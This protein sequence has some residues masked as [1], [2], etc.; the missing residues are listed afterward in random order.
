[1]EAQEAIKQAKTR[2]AELKKELEHLKSQKPYDEMTVSCSPPSP[3][4]MMHVLLLLL[5]N[6]SSTCAQI[7]E[8]LADKPELRRQIEVDIKNYH[9]Y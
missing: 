6:C 5:S 2:A 7:D 8:Y 1:M 4:H 9:W 3:Q